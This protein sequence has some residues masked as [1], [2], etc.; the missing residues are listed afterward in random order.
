[1][2]TRISKEKA[3]VIAFMISFTAYISLLVIIQLIIRKYAPYVLISNSC[4]RL[5]GKNPNAVYVWPHKRSYIF[6][7]NIRSGNIFSI[8]SY[9]LKLFLTLY[10][11][12]LKPYQKKLYVGLNY[13]HKRCTSIVVCIVIFKM[14]NSNVECET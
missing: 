2:A 10:T 6:S 9:L 7:G 5:K 1:M 4:V 8:E 11:N 14:E 13:V 3:H 12:P